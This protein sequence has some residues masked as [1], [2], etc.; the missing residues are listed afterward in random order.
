MIDF[1]TS[2]VQRIRLNNFQNLHWTLQP[3]LTIAPTS[4]VSKTLMQ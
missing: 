4:F 3:I 2:N 1:K